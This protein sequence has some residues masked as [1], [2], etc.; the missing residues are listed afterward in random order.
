MDASSITALVCDLFLHGDRRLAIPPDAD[1][2]QIGICDSLGLVRLA[3]AL[4]QAVPGLRIDDADVTADQLGS[5]NRIE[6]FLQR[7]R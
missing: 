1:F 4:E 7:R 5:V 6:A 2:L 3:A